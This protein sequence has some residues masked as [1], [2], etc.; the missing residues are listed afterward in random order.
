MPL[1][2]YPGDELCVFV[3]HRVLELLGLSSVMD[4]LG[5]SGTDLGQEPKVLG[6]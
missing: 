6:L 3:E 1:E 4:P 5:H 2:F